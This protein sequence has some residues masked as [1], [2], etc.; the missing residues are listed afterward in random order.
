M[1]WA[2]RAA[3]PLSSIASVTRFDRG[4]ISRGVHGFGGRWLVNGSGTGILD[5][6][7]RPTQRAFVMGFPVRLQHL[8]ISLDD[9][10][11]VEQALK[12]PRALRS[13]NV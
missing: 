10:A 6:E 9:S 1:G 3:F 2:F 7:L 8:L 11:G 4:T 13:R 5:I 12:A